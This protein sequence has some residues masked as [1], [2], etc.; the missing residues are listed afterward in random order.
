MLT[1]CFSH[2][3][4]STICHPIVIAK[5]K[6]KIKEPLFDQSEVT[7]NKAIQY[8]KILSIGIF[9]GYNLQW[10]STTPAC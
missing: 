9:N 3:I 1:Q 5:K 6:P 7:L 2:L 4:T 10:K 8:R